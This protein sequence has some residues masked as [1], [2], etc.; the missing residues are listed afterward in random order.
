MFYVTFE[1]KSA[2]GRPPGIDHNHRIAQGSQ[3]MQA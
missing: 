1:M 2:V 3:S